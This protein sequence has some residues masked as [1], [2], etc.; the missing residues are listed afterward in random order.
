[1][2][3]CTTKINVEIPEM[4]N[5]FRIYRTEKGIGEIAQ[6]IDTPRAILKMHP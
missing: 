2:K 4:G 6:V 1:M 5:K 3:S